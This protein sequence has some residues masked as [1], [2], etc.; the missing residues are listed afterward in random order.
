[1]HYKYGGIYLNYEVIQ[2]SIFKKFCLEDWFNPHT[3]A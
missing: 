3:T 2:K 1:M